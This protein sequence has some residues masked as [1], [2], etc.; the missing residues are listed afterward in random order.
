MGGRTAT[1]YLLKVMKKPRKRNKF[2]AIKTVVDGITFHSK[3]EAKRYQD[4]KSLARS[5]DI[6]KLELQPQ[7]SLDVN[8]HHICNYRGDFKYLEDGKEVIE[9][10]KGVKTPVYRIK[11]K[12]MKAIHGIEILET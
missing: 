10:S 3:K 11:K 1:R 4:L 5:G 7:F 6:F 8:G 12:L 9:D 2:G